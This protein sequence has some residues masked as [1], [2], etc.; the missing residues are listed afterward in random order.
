MSGAAEGVEIEY[1]ELCR[2][3]FSSSYI[4]RALP[5]LASN[6]GSSAGPVNFATEESYTWSD[7]DLTFKQSQYQKDKHRTSIFVSNSGVVPRTDKTKKRVKREPHRDFVINADGYFLPPEG[8]YKMLSTELPL[9]TEQ[10]ASALSV[11]TIRAKKE[12]MLQAAHFGA[13]YMMVSSWW[14]SVLPVFT[15]FFDPKGIRFHVIK[16]PA[17]DGALFLKHELIINRPKDPRDLSASQVNILNVSFQFKITINDNGFSYCVDERSYRFK[18]TQAFWR[19]L[20]EAAIQKLNGIENWDDKTIVA[21]VPFL[22]DIKFLEAFAQKLKTLPLDK[23]Q[24]ALL[25]DCCKRCFGDSFLPRLSFWQRH[26]GKVMGFLVGLLVALGVA[27]LIML[28][29]KILAVTAVVAVSEMLGASLATLALWALFM[30]GAKRDQRLFD[31][32]TG[33]QVALQLPAPSLAKAE[34]SFSPVIANSLKGVSPTL[35]RK[36]SIAATTESAHSS[37]QSS[38]SPSP[39]LTASDP[40]LELQAFD[41]TAS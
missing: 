11:L 31:V 26:Q 39:S 14:F 27:L 10:E 40:D 19:E 23:A 18:I 16:K 17:P 22:Q 24:S 37:I 4:E 2:L 29:P 35:P 5:I 15:P 3:K 30:E 20:L 25:A 38:K 6:E 8:D 34:D 9:L 13:M 12:E 28:W 36:P 32:Y 1:P 21:F 33:L 41:L 7:A